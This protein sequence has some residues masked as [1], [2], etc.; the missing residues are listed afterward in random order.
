[1]D[2][3]NERIALP[4]IDHLTFNAISVM[5]VYAESVTVNLVEKTLEILE[6]WNSTGTLEIIN[7]NTRNRRLLCW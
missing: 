5:I 2:Q 3:T 6:H 4:R 7:G 1:M